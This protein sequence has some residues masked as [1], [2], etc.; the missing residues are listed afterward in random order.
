MRAPRR[1]LDLLILVLLKEL[2]VLLDAQRAG[3]ASTAPAPPAEAKC[4]DSEYLQINT[5]YPGVRKVRSSPPIYV[6]E[7]FLSHEECDRLTAV[8][9]AGL[10]RSIVV[11]GRDGKTSAPSRTSSSCFLNKASEAW[12][13][14]KVGLLVAARPAR[15]H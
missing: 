13:H 9:G 2:H 6:C 7:G 3:M 10:K 12:L 4:D 8:G 14:K 15:H 11:D 5:A 1:T